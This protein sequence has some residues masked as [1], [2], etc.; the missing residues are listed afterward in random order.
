MHCIQL[1][2]VD[3]A[4]PSIPAEEL[5]DALADLPA[6]G[7]SGS[8]EEPDSDGE[9]NSST[10]SHDTDDGD[11]EEETEEK[12]ASTSALPPPN[13][14]KAP[15]WVDEDDNTL[16]V[17]LTE[18]ERLRKLREAPSDD[19]VGGRDYER[20]LRRQFEKINPTPEWA[21]KARKQLHPTKTKRR[22]SS[23]SSATSESEAEDIND[24]LTST[25]GILGKSRVKA[26]PKGTLSIERLRDANISARSEGIIKSVQF[27]PSPRLPVMLT[28]GADRRLKL[29]N[30][31]S[32]NVFSTPF[33]LKVESYRLTDTQIP[34]YKPYTFPTFPLHLHNS[35]PQGQVSFSP[36]L[37]HSITLTTSNPDK[38]NVLQEVFG[39][40]HLMVPIL[41]KAV[42]KHRLSILLGRY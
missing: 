8:D 28:A 27:H 7:E 10:I 1:F 5:D 23:V 34:I 19:V 4:N 20:R 33:I 36:A 12:I 41:T 25:G 15:A 6:G 35:I 37:A 9:E 29:F 2:F 24:L 11:D 18:N 13:A 38:L 3:D 31:S 32:V 22:R 42:W 40:P 16:E 26:L 39:V 14:R 21:A 17:S 30:V